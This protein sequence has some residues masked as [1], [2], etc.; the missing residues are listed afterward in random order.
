MLSKMFH[1]AANLLFLSTRRNFL[2]FNSKSFVW[3]L[4][5][6]FHK[7]SYVCAFFF[8]E[9]LSDLNQAVPNHLADESQTRLFGVAVRNRLS[10]SPL[11]FSSSSYFL[12]FSKQKLSLGIKNQKLGGDRRVSVKLNHS[13]H[14][15]LKSTFVLCICHARGIHLALCRYQLEELLLQNIILIPKSTGNRKKRD[16]ARGCAWRINT[17]WENLQI[18]KHKSVRWAGTNAFLIC[19]FRS[20]DFLRWWCLSS[21]CNLTHNLFFFIFPIVFSINLIHFFRWEGQCSRKFDRFVSVLRSP[22][23]P[24]DRGKTKSANFTKNGNCFE[25]CNVLGNGKCELS[26]I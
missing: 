19:V 21:K 4:L 9:I 17:I 20:A 25:E 24:F 6:Y 7:L 2:L 5:L 14:H 8:F 11:L 10:L 12:S 3:S 23:T 26:A 22:V 15:C 1:F 13:R 18:E 16:C